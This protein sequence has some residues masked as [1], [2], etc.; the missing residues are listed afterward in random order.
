MSTLNA[1]NLSDGTDTVPTT[2]LTGGVCKL[3]AHYNAI[4]NTINDSMNLSSVTDRASGQVTYNP[5][6]AF[7]DVFSQPFA[8]LGIEDGGDGTSPAGGQTAST[9]AITAAYMN[10]GG[11]KGNYVA[12]YILVTGDLA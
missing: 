8:M 1:A 12:N 11:T 2:Y 10:R 5:T 4:T 7:T 9:T 3:R 6:N